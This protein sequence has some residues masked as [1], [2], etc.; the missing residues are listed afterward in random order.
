MSSTYGSTFPAHLLFA[1]RPS[2]AGPLWG[3]ED[4]A[5]RPRWLRAILATNRFHARQHG[6]AMVIRRAGIG[7]VCPA[8][9]RVSNELGSH[10]KVVSV[11]P[12]PN[13]GLN[14]SHFG[15]AARA[16]RLST[17]DMRVAHDIVT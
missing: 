7:P 1:C 9:P 14:Q 2:C 16:C 13:L 5:S 17:E 8:N 15:H 3:R 4:V 12:S 11:L 6:H 10:D